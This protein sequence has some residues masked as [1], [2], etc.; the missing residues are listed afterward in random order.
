[1]PAALPKARK[2]S[3]TS[4]IPSDAI[5]GNIE[6]EHPV[7]FAKNVEYNFG[8]IG[9][10]SSIN[11]GTVLFGLVNIGRF[12]A[13]GRNCQIACSDHPLHYLSI[14]FFQIAG[15]NAFPDDPALKLVQKVPNSLPPWRKRGTENEIGNDV[16]IGANAITL[17]GVTIGDGAVVAAGAVVVK[18]VP[19]YA[20]VGGNPARI[21]KY[22]FDDDVIADL[23]ALKWWNRPIAELAT[24]PFDDVRKCIAILRERDAKSAWPAA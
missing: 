4:E 5:I 13:I 11:K 22:R 24:L 14:G 2:M 21:L 8:R 18:D 10:Y 20:V 19:P 9:H 15:R 16:W 17:Q 3:A 1:M 6:I 12:T 23:L 7:S